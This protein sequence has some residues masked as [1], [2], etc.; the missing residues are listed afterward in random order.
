MVLGSRIGL[1]I[2]RLVATSFSHAFET[3][4]AV[5]AYKFDSIFVHVSTNHVPEAQSVL[6]DATLPSSR[7]HNTQQ[8]NIWV[9]CLAT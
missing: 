5:S 1:A 6:V 4:R 8:M 9:C 3:G 2:G 7:V